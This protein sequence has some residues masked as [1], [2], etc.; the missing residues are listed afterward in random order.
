MQ[1]KVVDWV[2]SEKSAD[3]GLVEKLRVRVFLG[4]FGGGGALWIGWGGLDWV[5]MVMCGAC[6]FGFWWGWGGVGDWKGWDGGLGGL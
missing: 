6:F 4:F 5:G 3:K 2:A 1:A